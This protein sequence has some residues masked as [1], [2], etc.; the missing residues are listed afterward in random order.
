MSLLS[1]E[2]ELQ[3]MIGTGQ[4]LDAYDK[5]YSEDVVMEGPN[6]GSVAGK[7]AN[8]E[9]EVQ[10]VESIQ[11]IHGGGVGAITADEEAGVTMTESWMDVTFKDGNR[12]KL[13]QVSVKKWDGDQIKHERFYYNAG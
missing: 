9:R 10:F 2:Q 7:E 6:E 1:K 4:L 13:E 3:N 12:Y 11:D 8:R 5:F